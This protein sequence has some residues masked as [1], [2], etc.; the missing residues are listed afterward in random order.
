MISEDEALRIGVNRLNSSV[1]GNTARAGDVYPAM[2]VNAWSDGSV[3][4]QVFLD[5]PDSLWATSRKE[6]QGQ[7]NWSW[8]PRV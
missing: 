5:G 1:A 4:L 8:P 3:N 2:I 7:T 6:G